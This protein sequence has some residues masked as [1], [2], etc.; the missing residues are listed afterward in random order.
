M[1]RF[2]AAQPARY[3]IHIQAVELGSGVGPAG[4]GSTLTRDQEIA[5]ARETLLAA[6][7]KRPEVT[8]ELAAAPKN[9]AQVTEELKQRKLR[10][11]DLTLRL[12]KLERVVRPAAPG[13]KFPLLEQNIKLSLVGTTFP[14]DMLAIGGDGE[15]TVQTEVG[16]QVSER[17]ERDV[18]ND[19]MQD[20]IH[21][22]INQAL[23]KLKSG[24]MKPP[25]DKPRRKK[26]N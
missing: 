4:Q 22:A 6:L 10:G 19:A 15:A 26:P 14:G 13:K 3:Y 12:L 16:L 1:A 7:Q 21:Q 5:L 25:K 23:Q 2:A 18:L 8:M 20:A 17:Q 24:P 9:A 11:Y